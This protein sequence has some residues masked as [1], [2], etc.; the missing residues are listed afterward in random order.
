MHSKLITSHRCQYENG[1]EMY[2]NVKAR[3]ERAELLFFSN[4]TYC[5]VSFFVIA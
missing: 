4:L 5:F 1:K 2:Q 3:A